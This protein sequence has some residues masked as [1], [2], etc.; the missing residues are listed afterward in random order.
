MQTAGKIPAVSGFLKG[1]Q[2][3]RATTI[4]CVCGGRVWQ[5]KAQPKPPR[6]AEAE[7]DEDEE[8]GGGGSDEEEDEEGVE[9]EGFEGRIGWSGPGVR[10]EGW[11]GCRRADESQAFR[12]FQSHAGHG[13]RDSNTTEKRDH[14]PLEARRRRVGEEGGRGGAAARRTCGSIFTTRLAGRGEG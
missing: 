4:H 3:T 14:R 9:R 12:W 8:A 6:Q 1:V 13:A 7:E 2:L 11:S 5:P 10:D